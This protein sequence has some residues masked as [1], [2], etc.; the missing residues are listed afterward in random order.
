MLKLSSPMLL[1]FIIYNCQ[2]YFI[3]ENTFVITLEPVERKEVHMNRHKDGY[4]QF[5]LNA[6]LIIR[7]MSTHEPRKCIPGGAIIMFLKS[8]GKY[9]ETP[10][11]V[12]AKHSTNFGVI[13]STAEDIKNVFIGDN[14]H[15][16]VVW[17]IPPS[18]TTAYE[19][20]IAFKCSTADVSTRKHVK[21]N[22]NFLHVGGFVGESVIANLNEFRV[23]RAM[24]K[25]PVLEQVKNACEPVKATYVENFDLS[26]LDAEPAST[27]AVTHLGGGEE[28]EEEEEVEELETT[29]Y[30]EAENEL[31]RNNMN[32]INEFLVWQNRRA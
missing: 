2:S 31:Q 16:G 3:V 20:R 30:T 23:L 26:L 17:Q 32:L 6:E 10:I 27:A 15:R 24:R 29:G 9:E 5:K 8:A 28:E 4:M 11:L 7:I 1:Y 22:M 18:L 14:H 19:S 25:S 13:G 12:C 21:W